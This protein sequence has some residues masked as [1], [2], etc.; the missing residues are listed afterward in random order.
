MKTWLEISKTNLAHNAKEAL[1]RLAPQTKLLAV[2]KANAYGHGMTLVADALSAKIRA[3]RLWF[4]VDSTEEGIALRKHGI[5]API[6]VLGY[7]P[8]DDLALAT[9]FRL[10]LTVYNLE[11]VKRLKLGRIHIKLETGTTRQG[12]GERDALAIAQLASHKPGIKLVGLSTHYA[13]IEDTTDHRYAAMQL[14]RFCSA[15]DALERAGFKI[16]IRHT[17]ATAATILFPDTHFNLVRFGLGLYGLWPSKETKVSSYAS[18][19]GSPALKSA[20]IWKSVVAQIKKVPSGAPVSYGLTERVHR[21]SRVVVVPVGYSDGYPRALSSVGTVLI[22][23][24]RAKVL[25][26]VCMNM[27]LVDTTDISGV[28][29]EDEVVLLGQQGQDEITADELAAKVGTINYEIVARISPHLL[30]RSR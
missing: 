22:R 30:R 24:K 14:K 6:L 8:L 1:Q 18:K 15:A 12:V 7:T 27:M 4:G 19:E 20:L 10:D 23:G 2:V 26:R 3:D 16:P 29:L 5:R 13:N 21:A 25:G 11:T 28:R 17:A 9:R